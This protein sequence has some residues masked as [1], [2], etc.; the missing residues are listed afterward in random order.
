MRSVISTFL[1]HADALRELNVEK[2]LVLFL[3]K[4]GQVIATK[5]I[6]QH[7]TK[8][9]RFCA[10]TVFAPALLYGSTQFIVI[11]N[12]PSG[13]VFPSQADY[14]TTLALAEG[15]Q[16]LQIKLLDHL[17]V[18]KEDYFSFREAGVL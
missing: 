10:R 14:L 5:I 7:K 18:T 17:I 13:S 1:K 15:G 16:L 2:I 4:K 9:T 12:H 8:E 6:T 3:N 11:H